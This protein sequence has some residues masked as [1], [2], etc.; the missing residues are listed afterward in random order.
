M[1]QPRLDRAAQPNNLPIYKESGAN[2]AGQER[3]SPNNTGQA[4]MNM[5][6]V[7]R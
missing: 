5:Q 1:F 2:L 7:N 4:N 3:R 6:G